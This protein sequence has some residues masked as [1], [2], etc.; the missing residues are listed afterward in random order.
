M[1]SKIS[2]STLIVNKT[3]S[4]R[5]FREKWMNEGFQHSIF[6]QSLLTSKYLQ[7]FLL[8]IAMI[9]NEEY[10]LTY[11]WWNQYAWDVVMKLIRKGYQINI[12]ESNNL[13][14][15][16]DWLSTWTKTCSYI[17]RFLPLRLILLKF[18]F[19]ASKA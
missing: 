4:N 2:Q 10:N 16:F 5:N 7:S 15:V 19:A 18:Y 12:S 8:S 1:N 13:A 6:N 14:R 9:Q 17:I 3:S 11:H